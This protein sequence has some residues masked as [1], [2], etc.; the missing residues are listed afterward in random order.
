V[1]DILPLTPDNTAVPLPT[2]IGS[3]SALIQTLILADRAEK[4]LRQV[5]QSVRHLLTK[6]LPVESAEQVAHTLACGTWTHD[7]PI[8]VAEA[9]NLGLAVSTNM[10]REVFELMQLFPQTAQRR[11]SVEYIP[12]PYGPRERGPQRQAPGGRDQRGVA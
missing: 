7:Y 10:P 2:I 1:A 3:S 12:L 5:E 9:R 6:H 11:P 4:A 8:T